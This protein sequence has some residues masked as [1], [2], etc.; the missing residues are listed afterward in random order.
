MYPNRNKKTVSVGKLQV[1]D[2]QFVFVTPPE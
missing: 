1:T 2:L